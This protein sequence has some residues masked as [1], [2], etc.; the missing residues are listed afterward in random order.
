MATWIAHTT[1]MQLFWKVLLLLAL[2]KKQS[3]NKYM[4]T[5]KRLETWAIKKLAIRFQVWFPMCSH[6]VPQWVLMRFPTCSQCVPQDVLRST[7]LFI[8]Y[9]LANVVLLSPVYLCQ[10]GGTT[11]Y[12]KV[13]P[14]TLESLHSFISFWLMG[15]LNWD[16]CKIKMKIELQSQL[17]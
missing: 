12:F 1:S 11:L 6:Y 15:Q 10:R 7:S 2:K 4:P 16:R 13:E 5:Y 3:H 8:P 17:I 14:F 9:A